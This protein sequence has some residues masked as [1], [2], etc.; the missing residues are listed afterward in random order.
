MFPGCQWRISTIPFSH[1]DWEGGNLDVSLLAVGN[2][3][4]HTLYMIEG[5]SRGRVT[6]FERADGP[7][8]I[9]ALTGN[10]S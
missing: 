10:T 5:L 7:G 9:E 2:T 6:L 3:I 8:L 1:V 4:L